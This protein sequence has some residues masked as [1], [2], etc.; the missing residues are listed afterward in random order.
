MRE[1][2]VEGIALECTDQIEL[3]LTENEDPNINAVDAEIWHVGGT[4]GPMLLWQFRI[5]HSE[6]TA[7][8][9]WVLPPAAH[10]ILRSHGVAI[11]CMD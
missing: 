8:V 11:A 5:P 4:L 10:E 6:I 1:I 7:F 3:H 9:R 2:G